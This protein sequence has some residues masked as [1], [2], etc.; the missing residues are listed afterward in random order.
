[1]SISFR[2]A[3]GNQGETLV[4]EYL[5][6]QGF[7]IVMKNFSVRGG[8]IDLIACK[9]DVIAFIEVKTRTHIY[10]DTSEVITLAKQKKIIFAAK[11]FIAKQA[12]VDM[13][14]RFDVA[15]VHGEQQKEITYLE[16][17]FCEQER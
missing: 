6:K 17:A 11:F 2:R 4:E 10:F 3:L 16:N 12:Y 8:E 9:K 5:L 15:L 7:S 13:T 14:Y 1:M